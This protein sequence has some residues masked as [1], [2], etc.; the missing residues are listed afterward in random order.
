MNDGMK[1]GK[2]LVAGLAAGPRYGSPANPGKSEEALTHSY[3]FRETVESIV[4]AILLA[5]LFRTFVGEA[6]VIPTGSMAPTLQG[7]HKDV[8]CPKCKFGYQANASVENDDHWSQGRLAV[9][10]TTCPLCRYAQRIDV[11]KD[12]NHTSFAGDRILVNKFSYDFGDPRRWD[13]IVFKYPNNAK[14]NYIKRLVGLP[15]EAIKV[16]HGDV[17][18]R[19]P[20]EQSFKIARKPPHKL[21]AM[22]QV[23]DDN[24]FLSE[25]LAKGGWPSRWQPG[26]GDGA[27]G[28]RKVVEDTEPIVLKSTGISEDAATPPGLI[29]VADG[30]DEA[31]IRYRHLHPLGG[32]WQD[33]ETSGTLEP[34]SAGPETGRLITDFYAYNAFTTKRQLEP[35]ERGAEG[36][37]DLIPETGALGSHW[38]GDLALEAEVA[39][40]GANGELVLELVESGEHYQCRVDVATGQARLVVVGNARP[41]VDNE[42]RPASKPPTAQTSIRSGRKHQLR[43]SNID[44]EL[45]LW[46]DGT[47]I[48]FDGPTTYESPTERPPRWS[49]QDLGDLAPAGIGVRGVNAQ[50]HHLRILRDVYYIAIR[51]HIGGDRGTDYDSGLS[52][53]EIQDVLSHAEVWESS[54]LFA[55]RREIE[56]ELGADQFFPMGDN[57]P[58]SKDGRLWEGEPSVDRDLLTGKAVLVYWPHSW[59]TPIP[60]LP[61]FSRIRLIR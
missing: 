11:E 45:R 32:D 56:V 37:M 30:V 14:Q 61:N 18:I 52:P 54:K 38:V 55:S 4:V 53:D 7:N 42:G 5:F 49:P 40:D 1:R 41:F 17:L 21:V 33:I 20:G 3:A 34:P 51:A 47:V 24:G 60:F 43:F 12:P 9:A 15:G 31:W 10:A 46:V 23:V 6:F 35:N 25:E 27:S 39:V 36:N 59:N 19:K 29:R 26:L 44:D 13:V 58:Q 28:W 2:G 57:S 48:E 16:R 22:L 50:V 8:V